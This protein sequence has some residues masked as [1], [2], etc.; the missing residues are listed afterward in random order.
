MS[1]EENRLIRQRQGWL[2]KTAE[3]AEAWKLQ[4]HEIH[5]GRKESMLTVLEKR[6]YVNSTAGYALNVPESVLYGLFNLY[7]ESEM[8]WIS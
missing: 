3:A 4:S 7:A 8:T 2:R 5:S 6:G 1:P